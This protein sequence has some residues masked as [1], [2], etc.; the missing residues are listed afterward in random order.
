VVGGVCLRRG[1]N[2]QMH[3][4]FSE[5]SLHLQLKYLECLFDANHASEQLERKSRYGSK[6]EMLMA[7]SKQDRLVCDELCTSARKVLDGCAYNWIA[8]SFWSRMF[9]EV[10]AK[11]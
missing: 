9:G 8:P 5:R 11:Q 2:G 10:C 3:S 4:T 1:C 6:K 7:L